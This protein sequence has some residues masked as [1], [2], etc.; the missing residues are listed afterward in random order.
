MNEY[1]ARSVPEI[2]VHKVV[3]AVEWLRR[4]RQVEE[5]RLEL[6]MKD[7]RRY[8]KRRRVRTRNRRELT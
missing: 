8:N 1:I 3:K 5:I 2:S 6:F 7:R 4:K